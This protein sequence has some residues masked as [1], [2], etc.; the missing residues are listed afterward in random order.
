MC[1]IYGYFGNTSSIDTSLILKKLLHRGPDNQGVHYFS[2][3]LFAHTR[4]SIIDT[5]DRGR[6]PMSS[7]CGNY[8]IVF[9]GEIYN[10]VELKKKI[11]NYSFV[12]ETDT[13]VI[14]AAY[15]KWGVSCLEYFRGMFAFAIMDRASNHVFCATD[16]F[17][18]KPFYY[19]HDSSTFT[20]SSEIKPLLI[21]KKNISPNYT[22]IYHYLS[23]GG[24]NFSHETFFDKIFQ[25]Q[26]SH[27]L[28]FKKGKLSTHRYWD[29]SYSDEVSISVDRS[30][31]EIRE[32][33]EEAL[34]LHMRSDV[35]VGLSL[36]SGLDSHYILNWMR[37][38]KPSSK[39]SCFTF[40]YLNTNYDEAFLNEKSLNQ[41][42]E[43]NY[44][45]TPIQKGHLIDELKN[46][47]Y[48]MEEPSLGLATHGAFLNYQTAHH[49]KMK[50]LLD[51]QGADEIFGGYQYYM[52]HYIRHV[53]KENPSEAQTLYQKFKLFHNQAGLEIDSFTDMTQKNLPNLYLQANDATSM[54]S[55]DLSNDFKNTFK[56]SFINFQVNISCPV[57][58]AMYLD[59][60][61]LKIPRLLRFQDK[62]SMSQSI[63]V[64]VPFLDH[65]LVEYLFNLPTQLLLESGQPKF[66]LRSLAH[67]FNLKHLISKPKLYVSTPQ[68]EWIKNS[69]ELILDRLHSACPEVK[70]IMDIEKLKEKFIAYCESDT[71]GNSF[72]IWKFL[73]MDV[74]FELYHDS[75]E[76]RQ[77][78][79]EGWHGL[80]APQ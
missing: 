47:I 21:T 9:N 77:L 26:P 74:W 5:A 1:G 62:C 75:K 7:A 13:E 56:E 80:G 6:Q 65:R 33:L 12:T 60:F 63:E 4:L 29:L 55:H 37:R 76:N 32:R 19:Y 54:S 20:F 49:K 23:S 51:G 72:F 41:N 46:D 44:F 70:A 64:R 57:K 3:G 52:H 67:K 48:W 61:Y 78:N 16:R 73:N 15:I 38:N 11:R 43:I 35:D 45:I 58:K 30:T 36:S 69:R 66:L 22:M 42:K 59:L 50:V 34:H 24:L 8:T 17:S 18:I 68:R 28:I 25:L 10:Y 2:E 53:F 40:S 14:L 31:Q 71:L 79:V 27:Y 39:I